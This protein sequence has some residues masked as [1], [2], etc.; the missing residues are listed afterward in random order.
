VVFFGE[1][2][3]V[4]GVFRD[5]IINSGIS[6]IKKNIIRSVICRPLKTNLFSVGSGCVGIVRQILKRRCCSVIWVWLLASIP[7]HADLILS[8]PPR[9]SAEDGAILY[10]PLADHLS[11]LLGE[12]VTYR[13]PNN[14]LEYQR[15]LRKGVYDIVFDGPHFVSWRIEHLH[16]DVLVKLPGT[17][18]F[19]VVAFANDREIKSMRDLIGKKICG[20]PPPNLATLTVIDQFTNPVRQPIIWGVQGGN[21]EVYKSLKERECRAAVFRSEFYDKHL[22]RTIRSQM[23]E[24]FRSKPLPNQ[25]I[26]AG[27]RLNGKEKAKIIRSLTLGSGRNAVQLITNRFAGKHEFVVAHKKEYLTH[28]LLLEGIVFG[29]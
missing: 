9:E 8:A 26:S 22:T 17:L 2:F 11:R 5:M 7:A 1:L 6:F 10:G 27:P 25:A 12:K 14:W 16:H 18:E 3:F 24:L 20:V 29:W 19:V 15:D 23:K 13:H 4:A 28:N 21:V